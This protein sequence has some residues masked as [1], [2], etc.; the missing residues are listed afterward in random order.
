M[1]KEIAE[2]YN[3]ELGPNCFC[4]LNVCPCEYEGSLEL[5]SEYSADQ[6]QITVLTKDRTYRLTTG[7]VEVDNNSVSWVFRGI[8]APIQQVVT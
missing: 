5:Q 2:S 6:E 8:N 1:T 7:S 4:P 3:A